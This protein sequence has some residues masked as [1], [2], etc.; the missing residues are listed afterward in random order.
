M[1]CVPRAGRMLSTTSLAYIGAATE[2]TGDAGPAP[3]V[4]TAIT[5]PGVTTVAESNS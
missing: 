5:C 1:T 2:H 4:C 3:C